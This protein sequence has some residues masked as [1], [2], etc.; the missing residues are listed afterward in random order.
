MTLATYVIRP[1]VLTAIM[2]L[3]ASVASAPEIKFMLVATAG[4]AASFMAGC[5]LTRVPGISNVL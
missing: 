2:V 4:V 3:L 5:A 1:L